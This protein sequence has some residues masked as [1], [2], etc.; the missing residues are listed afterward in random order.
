MRIFASA[1]IFGLWAMPAFTQTISEEQQS[2]DQLYADY[3]TAV[4]SSDIGGYVNALHPDVRLL[5]PGAAAIV[6][7]SNYAGFLEPVF[8][9]ADYRIEVVS[10]PAI[11][12]MGDTAT[13]EYTYIIHLKLKNPDVGVTEPGALT[14]SRTVSRY[15]DVLRKHENGR[16]AIWRHTWTTLPE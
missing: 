1:I 6:G 3:R 2:I 9:T 14:D 16:W 10:L 5:P 12:V 11:E 4:E 13:A 8:A 7:A 15:F